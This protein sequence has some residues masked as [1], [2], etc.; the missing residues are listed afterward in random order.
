MKICSR[1]GAQSPDNA[2]FCTLCGTPLDNA[3]APNAPQPTPD[4][5]TYQSG[6]YQQNGA[7]PPAY[8][9]NN[10]PGYQPYQQTGS[11]YQPQQQQYAPP[12]SYPQSYVTKPAAP[13]KAPLVLGIIGAVFALLL[14]IVTYCCSIPGLVIAGRNSRAG[15]PAT[16]T[17]VL[18]IIALVVAAINSIAG[19]VINLSALNF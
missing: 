17:K 11:S 2:S 16:G 14:P 18:N 10:T 6:S 4:G 9:Q 19:V 12:P 5:Q 15:F 8:P 3:P 7:V 1:C 13:S